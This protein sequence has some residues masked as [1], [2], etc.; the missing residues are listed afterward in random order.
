MVR[1]RPYE[2][3]RLERKHDLVREAL[4]QRRQ[5]RL[6]AL[7]DALDDVPVDEPSANFTRARDPG[8]AAC[9]SASG[10]A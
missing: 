9:S 3:D 10:T 8:T 6:V 5:T 1:H 7:G 2:L 4:R